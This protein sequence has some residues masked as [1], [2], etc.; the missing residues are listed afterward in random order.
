MAAIIA[1]A[2]VPRKDDDSGDTPAVDGSS[3][4]APSRWRKWARRLAAL[5]FGCVLGLIVLEVGVLLLAGEQVK[6]PRRVVEAP[7]K[8]RYNDPGGSY[9]HK[10]AD[11]I[12]WFR[13]N[14]QGM[15]EDENF[16][17]AKPAGRLRVVSLG[18]SFTIGYE[19]DEPQCFSSV[20]ERQL[21]AEDLPVD[22]LNT[23]VSGFSNAEELAY[24]ER[25]LLKYEPDLVIVSFF[26]NDLVDN[27]RTGLYR[28]E[29]GDL[30]E[31]GERYVPLG[32]LANRLNSNP[33]FN[34][35][36]TYSNAFVFVKERLNHIIKR[37]IVEENQRQIGAAKEDG[38][39]SDANSQPSENPKSEETSAEVESQRRLAAAI[40][41]RMYQLLQ[42]RGIPLVIHSI[43]LQPDGPS[44]DL[45]DQFPLD[46]FDTDRPGI[47][48]VSSKD[49]LS[50]HVRGELLYWQRSHFHWTPFSHQVAGKE[51][52]R[53]IVESHALAGSDP[54]AGA[55]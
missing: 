20:I 9:R 4:P 51:I 35:A 12:W 8:L 28:L 39:T 6:F 16:T 55:P 49:V 3:V 43:P 40:F 2:A 30:L 48:Y 37:Q 41:E 42:Q 13:I 14:K 24:L 50:P 34:F 22:V 36:S 1:L 25:E 21:Q 5:S 52:A 15:R 7:W 11:G 10:S 27:L 23:G 18:D 26:G 54:Q 29:D 19:V 38:E 46:Y 53:R 45:I 32:E 17:H 47:L 33:L 31:W 44:G